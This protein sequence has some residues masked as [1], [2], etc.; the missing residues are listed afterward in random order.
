MN[1]ALRD[2]VALGRTFA[3]D[4]RVIQAAGGNISVKEGRDKLW[5]KASGVRLRQLTLK[6][7]WALGDRVQIFRGLRHVARVR[8]SQSREVAYA[9]LLTRSSRSDR[10]VSMEAGFHAVLPQIYLAHLHSLTA[11]LLGMLPEP[12]ARELLAGAGLGRVKLYFAPASVPG[13]ELTA[14]MQDELERDAST[15]LWVQ[16]NHGLVWCG[17]DRAGIARLSSRFERFTR[18]H[19]RLSRFPLP[20]STQTKGCE[21]RRGRPA[22]S[23]SAGHFADE[24]CLCAWPKNDFELTPLFPDFIVYFDLWSENP[25]DLVRTGRTR[26]LIR[27]K[28]AESLRDK[29]EVF[30]AH[31]VIDTVSRELGCRTP[32]P[33]GMTRAIK[34]MES[35][36]LR[37]KQAGVL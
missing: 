8:S 13:Y 33:A 22:K 1:R 12:R 21:F 26:V 27:A 19:F 36:R 2:L 30:F 5:I 15:A 3:H 37:L 17:A 16:R 25:E 31:A 20:H 11:I 35:E 28:S 24:Y 4:R 7:G 18:R 10:R 6:R 23:A 34:S 9:K 14:R 29:M 32:L